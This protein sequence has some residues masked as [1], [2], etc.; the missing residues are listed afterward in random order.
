MQIRTRFAPSPTGDMHI[1]N[2]RTAIFNWIIARQNKGA[3]F[4]RIEDTDE[5]RSDII[6]EKRIIEILQWM[7]LDFDLFDGKEV[8]KQS[9][10]KELYLQF[11]KRISNAYYCHC[12]DTSLCE[13]YMKNYSSGVLRFLVEKNKELDYQDLVF[14]HLKSS[15][16]Q[17]E[18]FALIR[19]DGS[20]TYNL[21]VVVDDYLMQIS[22]VIR[23]EDHKT[24]TF[25]Q[26]ML[27]HSM[28]FP[29]P[30]F[31]H[32]PIIKGKDGKKLSKREKSSSAQEL[33][34]EGICSDALFNILIKLGWSHGNE[35]VINRTRAL[36]IFEIENVKRSSATFETTKLYSFSKKYMPSA[37]EEALK[38][39]E[40]FFGEI[41]KKVFDYFYDE[42]AKKCNTFRDIIKFA[43]FLLEN[44]SLEKKDMLNVPL[45]KLIDMSIEE[46]KD[47]RLRI[48]GSEDGLS[49]S[50]LWSFYNCLV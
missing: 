38:F 24:N 7:H 43:P 20:P 29:I 8:L 42:L 40:K 9:E 37:K 36:E 3:F 16:N 1:G 27:Y 32:L 50:S 12:H 47:L 31:A 34:E 41:N 25:K 46:Q 23:G 22:H 21:A 14:G 30:K 10:R 45:Q 15:S 17:I 4:L 5:N 28:G 35:E 49:I 6:Y 33:Y 19:S 48:T 44:D 18:N 2:L 13:C 11:A 39:L 26:I